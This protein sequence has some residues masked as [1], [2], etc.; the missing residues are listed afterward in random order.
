MSIG[1]I[2]ELV[3]DS[4]LAQ[5]DALYLKLGITTQA[6]AEGVATAKLY[7]DAI[8][9]TKSL[10][11]FTAANNSAATAMQNVVTQQQSVVVAQQQVTAVEIEAS[12]VLQQYSGSIVQ[13]SKLL[14]EQKAE[15][16]S[17][18][19]RLKMHTAAIGDS[20]SAQ[21]KN[22]EITAKLTAQQFILKEAV[23]Q[24][25]LV[26]KQQSKEQLAEATSTNELNAQLNQLIKLQNTLSVSERES[27]AAGIQLQAA[28]NTT[29]A[30]VV[31][32]NEAQGKFNDNVGNYP[33]AGLA[34]AD[35]T[36][37]VGKSM[38]I[39]GRFANI[40]TSRL[41]RMAASFVLI[42]VALGALE[43]L[44]KW[45]SGLDVFTGRLDK[46]VQSWK[47]WSDIIAEGN[48][49][50]G[51]GIAKLEILNKAAQDVNL[52]EK[53]RLA[54]AQKMK[55]L[56]PD[57]LKGL[58]DEAI[59][60]GKVQ[61]SID[62]LTLSIE[63][64][65]LAEAGLSKIT[66]IESQEL[67]LK[68][69]RDKLNYVK[70]HQQSAIKEAYTTGNTGNSITG[71]SNTSQVVSVGEQ[72]R[73]IKVDIDEKQ[74][75][76]NAQLAVLENTKK[77]IE[78][79]IGIGSLAKA[80]EKGGPKPKKGPKDKT[81][82]YDIANDKARLELAKATAKEILD[83][84]NFSYDAR[85]AALKTFTEK[86]NQLIELERND[87]NKKSGTT[88]KQHDTNNIESDIQRL[89]VT[90]FDKSEKEKI[91]A[92]I[93]KKVFEEQ[94]KLLAQYRDN[95]KAKEDL[96]TN[97]YNQGLLA[98]DYTNSEKILKITD[99]YSK[100]L[101][102]EKE[103][104]I[105]VNKLRKEAAAEGIDIQIKA[106][107]KIAEAQ[108]ASIALGF[109]DPKSLQGTANRITKLKV[110]SNN[111]KTGALVDGA[112]G[113][114]L[115]AKEKAKEV[116]DWSDKAVQGLEIAGQLIAQ[117]TQAKIDALERE[118]ALIER[119]GE[120]EKTRINGSLLSSKEKARQTAIIDIQ[121]AQQRERI[122]L[123]ENQAKKKQAEFDKA[124]AIARIIQATA[125]A[126]VE[127]LPNIF[128]AAVVGALG[129][130]QLAVAV[131]SPLPQFEKGGTV[132][133]D[134][135]IITGEAGTELR[136]DPSGKTSFTADHSNVSYAK[137][138]TKIISNTE[139]VKMFGKPEQLQYVVSAT[140]DNKKMEKLL[141][142]NNDLLR[143]QKSANIHIH[144]DKW[145]SYS[146]Q[147]NY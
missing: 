53:E 10:S 18:S 72:R 12:K 133:K 66:S 17:V 127:S 132:Q 40:L 117:N 73:R 116:L 111:L 8:G 99:Q 83:N 13:N 110:E 48:K 21:I 1:K 80:A 129:A 131:A 139:L 123:Q 98:L 26:I 63:K 87:K 142:E 24:T 4:A 78:D 65:A 62:E 15:L 97:G 88:P 134:G 42:T 58:E 35:A 31:S 47:A 32:A 124:T 138:G 6:M 51:E 30:S 70:V 121:T 119:N 49:N 19:E 11:D 28:I 34:A 71:T 92:E 39:T 136:I 95:E 25:T 82:D 45:I 103:Y 3:D 91:Q 85:L 59:M 77:V 109:G 102:S 61:K 29:K 74:A 101:F 100:G 54:A 16:A 143:K 36:E 118:F 107:E 38:D 68:T 141:T 89:G 76:I 5:L 113:D 126:V 56:W 79:N 145:G 9:Q 33:K 52:S 23:A 50:A 120:Y 86:S 90:A 41:F 57:K 55:E 96:I 115:S 105:Q 2:N 27:T 84:E 93:N 137:A 114:K 144:G 75:D 60:N 125:V 67:D 22:I 106:L 108:A 64:Q 122:T 128:L 130:A 81:V 94:A 46:A 69:Q 20:S 14:T 135:N 104:N 140:N 112:K 147:R 44:A 7:I 37:K 43:W 146:Q